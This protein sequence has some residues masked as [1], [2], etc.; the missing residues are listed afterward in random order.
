MI[1]SKC[2]FFEF[3][4][5]FLK[6]VEILYLYA[7]YICRRGNDIKCFEFR[8]LYSLLTDIY[9]IL[10]IKNSVQKSLLVSIVIALLYSHHNIENLCMYIVT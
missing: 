1:F 3:E 6:N 8:I 4:N 10:N 5:L 9:Y 2:P 7:Y